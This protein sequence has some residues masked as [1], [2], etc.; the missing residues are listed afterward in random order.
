MKRILIIEDND[1]L[2][3][4][5]TEALSY[6]GF[7][8][9]KANT[10]I[11]GI[12]LAKKEM[13]DLILCDIMMPEIDG[14]RVLEILKRE[15]QTGLIPF[16]FI[17]SLADRTYWRSGMESG[18]DD[19]LTKP[20]TIKE[21]VNAINA[22]LDRYFKIQIGSTLDSIEQEMKQ[23]LRILRKQVDS[24]KNELSEISVA[25]KHLKDQ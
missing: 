9:L 18:A 11:I 12:E 15:K 23:R 5:V 16:I 13:P 21:L 4:D 24:H 8:V 1:S 10:G 3:E 25:N 2:R 22:R 20:F 7:D 6:E 19:Y 14:F 17:T